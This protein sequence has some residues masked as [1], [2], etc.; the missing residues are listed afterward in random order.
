MLTLKVAVTEAFKSGSAEFNGGFFGALIG[1]ILLTLGKAPAI[2]VDLVPIFVGFY[3]AY[4]Y[5]NY[6][7]FKGA[8]KPAADTYKRLLL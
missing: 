4:G 8:A 1:W 6:S 7:V 3:A 5:N 2:I